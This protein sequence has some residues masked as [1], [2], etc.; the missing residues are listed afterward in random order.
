V[1]EAVRSQ[2]H[3]PEPYSLAKT[4]A[5]F[6]RFPDELVDLVRG[7]RY[8]RLFEGPGGV[9]LATA[10]QTSGGSVDIILQ[11]RSGPDRTDL[12]ATVLR[13]VRDV[14]ALEED[15]SLV[16]TAL[17]RHPRL[18]VI[19][20]HLSGL[21][22]V[23]D[24]SPIEGLVTS[25]L[26]QQITIRYAATLRARLAQQYGTCAEFDGERYLTFPSVQSLSQATEPDLRGL[27]MTA[28]KARA[29]AYAVRAAGSGELD[30]QQLRRLNDSQVIAHL[31][32]FPGVGRWT[33]EWFLVNVLGRTAVV[34]A[35]DLAIRRETGR[36]CFDGAMPTELET[37]AFYDRFGE[38][39]GYVAYYVLSARRAG[40]EPPE[41]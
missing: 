35:G 23:R 8:R 7:G 26:S 37:R 25:I 21:R 41:F 2:E 24:P 29:I 11:A 40:I 3:P 16:R 6:S 20:A 13:T 28:G 30:I 18:A 10:K 9:V 14:L 36:W 32:R 22:R 27:G 33:A 34:P 39:Q 17:Q 4:I 15:I 19:D 1:S 5:T 12:E 38:V 31:V